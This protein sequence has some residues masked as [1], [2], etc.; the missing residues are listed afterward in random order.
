MRTGDYIEGKFLF[1]GQRGE[2]PALWTWGSGT[3]RAD[4]VKGHGELDVFEYHSDNPDLLEM[5][6]HA[7]SGGTY[8]RTPL[9]R[10]GTWFTLGVHVHSGVLEWYL[11]GQRIYRGGSMPSGWHANLIL[12]QSV[13][14]GR[15]HPAPN[16]SNPMPFHTAYLKVWR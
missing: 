16:H 11:N 7:G 4:Y 8:Y 5:T 13:V 2:W 15:Y 14:A 6:N 12:N 9:V 10:P 1:S 3:N